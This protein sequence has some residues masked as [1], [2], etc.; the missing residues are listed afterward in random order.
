MAEAF[1]QPEFDGQCT[2]SLSLGKK[3]IAGNPGCY[4]VHAGKKYLFANPVVKLL[5]KVIP[6]RVRKAEQTWSQSSNSAP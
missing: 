3:G 4:T 2:F 1:Q 6:D 5:W